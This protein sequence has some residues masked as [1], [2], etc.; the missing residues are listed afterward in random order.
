MAAVSLDGAREARAEADALDV[1][2]GPNAYS[3]YLRAHGQRPDPATAATIGRLIDG[4]VRASDDRLY[5]AL[6]KHDRARR[7]EARVRRREWERR[8]DVRIKLMTALWW[9]DELPTPE[10][11]IEALDDPEIRRLRA[12][13]LAW[14]EHFDRLASWHDRAAA[15]D[16]HR[17]V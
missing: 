17:A 7:R 6:T 14:L 11:A 12:S 10:E 1:R 3:D 5:P 16:D 8:A 13:A 4:R 2:F 15:N 9:L